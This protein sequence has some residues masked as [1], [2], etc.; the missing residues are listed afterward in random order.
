MINEKNAIKVQKISDAY[1]KVVKNSVGVNMVCIWG[2][3][4]EESKLIGTGF[5]ISN[6][7]NH[8]D[9]T[10]ILFYMQRNLFLNLIEDDGQNL[11]QIGA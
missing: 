6:A 11:Q 1:V 8:D 7:I 9:M 4:D 3:I 2:M 5:S 10:T